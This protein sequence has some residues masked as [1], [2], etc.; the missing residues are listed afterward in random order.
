[1]AKQSQPESLIGVVDVCD[2]FRPHRSTEPLVPFLLAPATRPALG[3]LRPSVVVALRA[4][5]AWRAAHGLPDAWDIPAANDPPP[6]VAFAPPLAHGPPAARTR[7]LAEMLGRWRAEANA[8]PA[9]SAFAGVIGG[10]RW[11]GEWYDVHRTPGGA[12]RSDARDP[13]AIGADAPEGYLFSVERAAAALFGVVT[14]GVHMTIFEEHP[15]GSVRLWVPRRAATKP[16]FPGMLDNSVAGG[17]PGGTTVL[18]TI[19][20][21]AAEEASLAPEL[22]RARAQPVGAVSYFYRTAAGWLQPEV[23]YVYDMRLAPGEA[24]LAP[25]D[26]EVESFKLMPLDE[27][28]AAVRAGEFKPN[29]ALVIIDF[30]VRHGY[31]TPENE[32]RYLE[33]TQR[34]HGQFD[35]EHW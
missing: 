34:L 2:N 32:P 16:T 24:E 10:T 6:H 35:I 26:G 11:R 33:I 21:E 18:D 19:V 25:M 17:I 12:L 27:V 28:V 5:N 20:K 29:C 9:A 31:L 15:G 4:D 7:A 22:V 3:L 14:Y 23:E 30:M 1:M 13:L 8:D